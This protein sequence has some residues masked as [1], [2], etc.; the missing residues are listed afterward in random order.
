MMHL[1]T[2]PTRYAGTLLAGAALLTAST[3]A[4]RLTYARHKSQQI[5][6]STES[7]VTADDGVQLHV[8]IDGQT[9]GPLTIVFVH[10]FVARL[11]EFD[12]QRTALR[13]RG[14]LVLF[15]QRG[16]GS[17]GWGRFR[18][19]TIDQ[20]GRD[21]G[22]IVD[23]QPSGPVIL[24]AHSMG[25]MAALTLARQRPD[26][27]GDR[28]VGAALLSTAA[29]H[30]P[31]TAVPPTAAR[32][33]LR[34]RLASAAAWLLWLVAPIIERIAPFRRRRGRQWLLDRLFGGDNPPEEA[35][36]IMQDSWIHT[37]LSIASAFYP[38]LVTYNVPAALD[39]LRKV[40]VLILAG[41]KDR[42]IPCARSEYLAGQIGASARLVTVQGA[43]H[44]VNLTHGSQV[45]EALLE[46][47][48]ELHPPGA[49]GHHSGTS[50]D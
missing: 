3:V 40:P 14:R 5:H 24:V 26:L 16:H 47:I 28:I 21:L 17:S 22:T 35:A 48:D 8:E 44:M 29:G 10:G 19:A 32:V 49:P 31:A 18:A 9:E 1:S 45:N 13:S 15:D 42:A 43:G 6:A 50:H 23:Q 27:F 34:F 4:V 20:L 2:N 39:V 7:T 36:A 25:G 41:T 37:P 46:L 38:A 11:Q 12:A 30:L 33:A